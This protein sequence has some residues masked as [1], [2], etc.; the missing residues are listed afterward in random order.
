MQKTSLR[1]TKA[2]PRPSQEAPTEIRHFALPDLL[3]PEH[4]L[5]L[6]L[7]L[8]T[9]AQLAS[10]PSSNSQTAKSVC[11]SPYWKPTPTTV[12]TKSSSLALPTA[13]SQKPRLSVAE[14]A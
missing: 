5:A 9:L 12:P 10:S 2:F 3:P 7:T 6:N 11:C 1:M 14:D 8:G 4:H 13:R